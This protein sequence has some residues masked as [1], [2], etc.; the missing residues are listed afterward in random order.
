MFELTEN[1]PISDDPTL[2]ATIRNYRRRGARFALDD[3]GAGH[4]RLADVRLVE[5]E[6]IKLDRSLIAG[7]ELD[8]ARAA[9]VESLIH[10]AM[11]TGA[12]VCAEGVETLQQL[13]WLHRA[14]VTRVQGYLLGRPQTDWAADTPSLTDTVR[15]AKTPGLLGAV[16]RAATARVQPRPRSR[17]TTRPADS[18]RPCGRA[19]AS[20]VPA[21]SSRSDRRRAVA[22]D[23]RRFV[24]SRGELRP[25]EPG[26]ACRR[27]AAVAAH[28]PTVARARA[29]ARGA[30]RRCRRRRPRGAHAGGRAGPGSAATRC[31]WTSAS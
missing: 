29:H 7:L 19:P 22:L 26:G 12:A 9:A 14:G 6:L 21:R 31:R 30:R 23:M 17:W 4:A 18:D 27:H 15:Q 2:P 3:V 13:R 16:R 5:P 28:G 24:P 25:N 1:E 10:A 11:S 20:R 8:P